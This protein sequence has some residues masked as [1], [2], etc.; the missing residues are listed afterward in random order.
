[1]RHCLGRAPEEVETHTRTTEEELKGG[2]LGSF[3][4]G[5]SA[6]PGGEQSDAFARELEQAQREAE[7][8][9]G[10]VGPLFEGL[11][12]AFGADLPSLGQ[13]HGQPAAERKDMDSA[14]TLGRLLGG[15]LGRGGKGVGAERRA[16]GSSSGRDHSPYDDLAPGEIK[17]V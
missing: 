11:F 3:F 14:G 8:L 17:E 7:E 10:A 12:R 16:G 2:G 1:M 5:Y 15:F 9:A 6:P 4:G 13:P